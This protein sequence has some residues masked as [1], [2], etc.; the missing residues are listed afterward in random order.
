MRLAYSLRS[1]FVVSVCLA[2]SFMTVSTA[3]EGPPGGVGVGQ[4]VVV[5]STSKIEQ[6]LANVTYLLRAVNQPEIGGMATMTVNQFSRG[7]DR[8]RPI[9]VVV[10]LNAAGNPVPVVLLPIADLKAFFAGL[11]N[12]GEPEDLG[13]GLYTMDIG[14]RPFFAKQLDKWLL[15]GQQEEAVKEFK[16]IPADLLQSLS[17]RYDIGA[18]LDVQS[19]PAPLRDFL[20][21]QLKES[22]QRGAEDQKAKLTR[23]L[24]KAETA[25]TTDEARSAIAGRKAAMIA[26][27]RIQADQIEQIEDMIQNTKQIVLGLSSDSANKQI[28][29]EAASEFVEGS[30]LDARVAR[31]ATAKTKFAG[32][33]GEDPVIS[34]AF[35]D[36][37]DPSQIPQFEQ[38]VNASMDAFIESTQ[39]SSS[40]PGLADFLNEIKSIVIKSIQDGI[41]DSSTTITLNQGLNIVT[42][43]HIAD[44][45]QLAATLEKASGTMK[46]GESAPQIQFNAYEHQ[47]ASI[48]LGSVKLPSDADEVARK[49]FSDTVNIAIGTAGTAVYIAIGSQAEANLKAALDRIAK[50]PPTGGTPM[51]LKIEVGPLLAYIQSI[52]PTPFVEAMIQALQ[53]YASND[54]LVVKSEIVPHGARVRVTVEEGILRAAG[55]A[56]KAGQGN[57]RGGGF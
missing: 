41:V 51:E 53:N 55:A 35:A 7:L 44:G 30:K 10:S 24:E 5:V 57:R 16:Q 48:H 6:L 27:E 28:F 26:A 18:R 39:K 32:L 50:V 9:G 14:V 23:E 56:I 4:P 11:V 1:R 49:V 45:K 20:L 52:E 33:K 38:W 19:I 34:L 36:L 22:Y 12:F 31:S 54:M 13:D 40:Q 3:Q 37:M 29:L 2:L 17:S 25:A 47:G 43:A 15:V 42:A 8:T 46:K 21:G